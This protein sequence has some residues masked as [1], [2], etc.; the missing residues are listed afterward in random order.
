MTQ[1]VSANSSSS[2]QPIVW[3]AFTKPGAVP[4]VAALRDVEEHHQRR[5]LW[6]HGFTSASIKEFQPAVE[7][8][9][10]ELVEELS[11]RTAPG[12]NGKVN[13]VD[14]AKWLSNYS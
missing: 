7:N 13:S 8:R 11:K 3:D 2:D 1:L 4:G 6:N 12:S 9:V 10:L 14:L 5:K